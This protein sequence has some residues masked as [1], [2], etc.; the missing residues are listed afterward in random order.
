VTGI[1]GIGVDGDHAD[2]IVGTM[3]SW[4][5]WVV[6]V[7]ATMTSAIAVSR[8]LLRGR[9]AWPW[10]AL[11]IVLPWFTL[12]A[13]V[14]AEL[15]LAPAAFGASILAYVIFRRDRSWRRAGVAALAA[16][17]SIGT[18]VG[19]YGA[20]HQ[21]GAFTDSTVRDSYLK[22]ASFYGD[23]PTGPRPGGKKSGGKKAASTQPKKPPPATPGRVTQWKDALH[24]A[25]ESPRDFVVGHGLGSATYAENLGI[26][27]S[28]DKRIVTASLNSFGTLVVERGFL[29][30][31]IVGLCAI[32]LG[33][34]AL[35]LIPRAPSGEWR[36]AV[37]LGFPGALLVMIGG[38]LYASPFQEPAPNITFWLLTSIVLSLALR[39][40]E[41][42][43]E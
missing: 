24:V 31:L 35:R 18:I 25:Q 41:G 1:Q 8:Y 30:L 28:R 34:A 2:F 26:H 42:S 32:A 22:D 38:A 3:G 14:K 10:L 7:V 13:L 21:L 27:P 15:A 9:E 39:R 23:N 36:S 29:G 12:W 37:A 20:R 33:L 40:G 5:G 17:I 4:N 43:S 11:A 19:V 6:G 16:V